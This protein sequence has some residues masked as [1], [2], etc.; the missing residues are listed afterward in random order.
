MTESITNPLDYYGC[1][2]AI[3]D[4]REHAGLFEGLPTGIPALCKVVQGVLMH[5]DVTHL[6]GLELSEE[7]KEE[8]ELRHV[9]KMLARIHELDDRPLTAPRPPEKQLAINCRDFATMLCAMLRH[10]GISA[11][12]RCGFAAYF[13]GP[14]LKA[15]FWYDHWVC[16]Y[17]KA[18]EQRWVLVDAEVDE[19]EREFYQVTIDTH[20]VPRD[21]FLVAGKAW[22]LCHAG[23]VDPNR[24]G[25]DPNGMRGM[26]YIQS[27]LVRD[28]ASLNKME[29]LCWDCWG[30]GDRGPDSDV[31]A[32]EI[33]LL[34]RV[35][36]LTLADIAAFPKL[37]S[38]Y[39]N[40][41]RLRVPSVVKS[42]TSKGVLTIDMT[43]QG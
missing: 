30:L 25:L 36:A 7:R 22:Q 27:Q 29:L 23:E 17:W 31:S 12:A 6:Y 42:Y 28:F 24:F 20:D 38:T 37:R 43:S 26:W 3:T 14:S 33:A 13:G 40:D 19:I 21:Q 34:G 11:R 18:D 8:R 41:A 16:E 9:A 32:E 5:Y 15:D 1:H 39:E 10:Q 35:A 2:S 4:P